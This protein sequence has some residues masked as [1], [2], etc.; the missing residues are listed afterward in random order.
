MSKSMPAAV[1]VCVCVCVLQQLRVRA[2]VMI[3][4]ASVDLLI[5]ATQ[6]SSVYAFNRG[7]TSY[8]TKPGQLKTAYEQ[9][10]HSGMA[11]IS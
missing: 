2:G 11:S 10:Q 9:C 6:K 4:G 1:T 5:V 8:L 7:E 3:D